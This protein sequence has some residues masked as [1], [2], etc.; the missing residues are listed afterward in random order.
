MLIMRR[1]GP[2]AASAVALVL[3]LGLVTAAQARQFAMSGRWVQRRGIT[4]IP[5]LP[6]PYGIPAIPGAKASVQTGG[7]LTVPPDQFGGT[8]GFATPLPQPSVI[9]IST[10]FQNAGP[11]AAGTFKAGNWTMTRTFA[12]FAW[13]PGGPNPAC[14][15]PNA[16]TMGGLVRYTAGPNQYGGTMQMFSGGGGVVS[17]LSGITGPTVLHDPLGF[18]IAGATEGPGGPYAN[19]ADDVL[20]PGPITTGCQFSPH[21]LITVPGNIVG[22]GTAASWY[23]HGFPW[24]TGQV[25]V[26]GTGPGSYGSTTV[27]LTGSKSLTPNGAGNITLVAGGIANGQHAPTTY[28][29]FD[30]VQMKLSFP[31]Q[32]LPSVTPAGVAAG[33]VLMALAVGYALRRRV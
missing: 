12:N 15:S 9:Q 1:G 8:W 32:P 30:Y 4:Y 2:T 20:S 28:M 10:Q 16:G 27:T 17:F 24:T 18:G 21:G 14:P 7:T 23:I 3:L 5:L 25:Y 31:A 19:R 11:I 29:M 22:Y 33:A 6:G 13:C 26:R